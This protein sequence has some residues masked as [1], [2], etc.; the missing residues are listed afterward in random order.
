VARLLPRRARGWAIGALF[1]GLAV[2]D[3]YCLLKFIIPFLAR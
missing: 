1:A 2:L 3:V